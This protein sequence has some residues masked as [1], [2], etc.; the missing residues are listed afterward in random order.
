ME[1]LIF[2]LS[3]GAMLVV[4]GSW[5]WLKAVFHTVNRRVYLARVRMMWRARVTDEDIIAQ[6][7]EGVWLRAYDEGLSPHDAIFAGTARA[8]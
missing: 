8:D 6:T 7:G 4:Y 2:G 1:Q 3:A 5:P